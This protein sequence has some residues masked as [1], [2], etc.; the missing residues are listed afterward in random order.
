MIRKRQS[1]KG[2]DGVLTSGSTTC[3]HVNLG[4]GVTRIC[5]YIWQELPGRSRTL[6]VTNRRSSDCLTIL[7]GL[8]NH[9]LSPTLL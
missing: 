6:L 5:M 7:Q 2:K 4:E 1:D 8:R 9:E 3:Q